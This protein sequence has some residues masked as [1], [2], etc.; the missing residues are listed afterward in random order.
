VDAD[1]LAPSVRK[2]LELDLARLADEGHMSKHGQ[3]E[4]TFRLDERGHVKWF[5]SRRIRVPASE[6]EPERSTSRR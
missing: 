4:V 6:L 5:E 1:T 3:R 2:L